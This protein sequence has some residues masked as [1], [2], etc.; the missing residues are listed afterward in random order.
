MKIDIDKMVSTCIKNG[1]KIYPVV[2][3]TEYVKGQ[4]SPKCQIEI[5]IKGRSIVL[6][7]LYKQDNKLY[8]IIRELYIKHYN[9]YLN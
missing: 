6:P 8:E 4:K 7:D 9:D 3:K 1:I 5:N 2:Y